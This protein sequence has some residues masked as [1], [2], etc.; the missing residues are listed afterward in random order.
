[1]AKYKIS[2]SDFIAASDKLVSLPKGRG[3]EVC[4]AGRSNVGKSSLINKILGRRSLARTGKTPGSTKVI[5]LYEVNFNEARSNAG[6]DKIGTLADLP[7]YGYAKTSYDNRQGWSELICAY[8]TERN[9]LQL[10]VLLVDIRRDLEFEEK[11]II[12]LGANFNI[13]LALTKVDKVKKNEIIKRANYFKTESGIPSE[14]IILT[15]S[16]STDFKDGME[17]LRDI[18]CAHFIKT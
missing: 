15:S 16:E 8:L 13:V 3:L 11:E 4:L 18:I 5:C 9:V 10:V 1:M 12:K 14:R 17:K 2:R 7:G 6:K